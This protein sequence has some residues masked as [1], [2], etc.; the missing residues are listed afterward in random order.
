M[1]NQGIAAGLAALV[2]A[3]ACAARPRAEGDAA[4]GPETVVVPVGPVTLRGLLWRP[5]GRGPFPAVLLLHG[6]GRT[7]EDL[8]RLGPYEEQAPVLG[9]V[10]ARHGYE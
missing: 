5:Q 6:S 2:L 9:P 10:F 3:S 4:R 7:P 8:K 1:A